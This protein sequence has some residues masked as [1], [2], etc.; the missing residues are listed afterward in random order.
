MVTRANHHSEEKG[1]NRTMFPISINEHELILLYNQ[2]YV[3]DENRLHIRLQLFCAHC[4]EEY[5]IRG[6]LPA[7][8][9]DFTYRAGVA[10][11]MLLGYFQRHDCT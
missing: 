2:L 7:E 10:K 9:T 8:Y 4:Q 11:F 6:K 5:V 3:T 1:F